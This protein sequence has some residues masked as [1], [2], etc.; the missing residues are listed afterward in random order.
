MKKRMPGYE[1]FN[2]KI[3][4][5]EYRE[6]TETRFVKNAIMGLSL[7]KHRELDRARIKRNEE[8]LKARQESPERKKLIKQA[9]E[10][11]GYS[12]GTKLRMAF[13]A[14]AIAALPFFGYGVVNEKAKEEEKKVEKGYKLD[15]D[16]WTRP[17]DLMLAGMATCVSL[18]ILCCIAWHLDEKVTTDIKKAIRKILRIEELKKEGGFERFWAWLEKNEEIKEEAL[19]ILKHLSK[20]DR[21]YIDN[22]LKGGLDDA[23]YSTALAI[24]LGYLE[25]HPEEYNKITEIINESDLPDS[26]KLAY[27]STWYFY[28]DQMIDEEEYKLSTDSE[29]LSRSFHNAKEQVENNARKQVEELGSKEKLKNIVQKPHTM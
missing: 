23:N 22:L 5:N 28:A 6:G 19:Y 12:F 7:E 1:E 8:N 9:S 16:Y 20:E 18:L 15:Y 26:I 17:N 25:K 2:E 29:R 4:D 14:V 21:G 10:L 13:I 3:K 24:I 11:A 27:G